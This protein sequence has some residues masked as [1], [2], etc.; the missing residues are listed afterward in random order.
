[1]FRI[2]TI[3][4]DRNLRGF[5]EEILNRFLLNKKFKN[6][7]AE[8]FHDGGDTYW[9][10]LVEYDP[11]VEKTAEDDAVGLDEGQKLLL[12]RLRAWRKE[13][14]EKQRTISVAP[15]KDRV[16]HHAVVGVLEPVY[17]RCFIHDSYATR[18]NKGTH[19]ALKRAQLFMRG[20]AWYLK[21]G[22]R[23]ILRQY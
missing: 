13:T 10:V 9:T 14:A 23:E 4:F 18:K 17:E 3:P 6:Y 7:K 12:E 21:N 20:N 2:I 5:D 15:F 11:L 16:V 22:C 1:M 8:L 19:R